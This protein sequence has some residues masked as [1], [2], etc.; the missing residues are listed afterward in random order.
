MAK[1]TIGLGVV[2][3]ALGVGGYFGTG[4]ESWTALIPAGFGLP[5]LILGLVA[6]QDARRKHAM[7]AAVVLGV[8]GFGGTAGGL[9]TLLTGGE[10]DR[11]VAVAVKATMAVLC[12]VYV[13]LCVGSFIAARRAGAGPKES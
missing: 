9:Y 11:P 7:H 13:V 5:L 10:V 12:L 4:R 1:L 8:L 2:L 3:I 6:L